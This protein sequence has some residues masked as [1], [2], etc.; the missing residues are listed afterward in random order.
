MGEQDYAEI[1]FAGLQVD[2]GEM[3]DLR[4]GENPLELGKRYHGRNWQRFCHLGDVLHR[5]D[6]AL[7]IGKFANVVACAAGFEIGEKSRRESLLDGGEQTAP[8]LGDED[9]CAIQGN[10]TAKALE[11]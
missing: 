9:G 4:F 7:A 3:L 11:R 6:S 8:G 2:G 10:R 1:V 5:E